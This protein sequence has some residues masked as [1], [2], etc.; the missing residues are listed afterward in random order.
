MN[1]YSIE[2]N[3]QEHA[4]DKPAYKRKRSVQELTQ[5]CPCDVCV[6]ASTCKTEC[7][8]FNRWC[9]TGKPQK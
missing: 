2:Q 5:F 9:K 8:K 6:W 4:P 7:P 1:N 3:W